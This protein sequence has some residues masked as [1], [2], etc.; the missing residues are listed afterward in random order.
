MLSD[1]HINF[2]ER[3]ALCEETTN[4]DIGQNNTISLTSS[5]FAKAVMS[6]KGI[7]FHDQYMHKIEQVHVMQNCKL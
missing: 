6:S 3:I 2:H 1:F 7:H 4:L 5:V